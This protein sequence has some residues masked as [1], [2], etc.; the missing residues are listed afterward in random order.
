[1]PRG[2]I[3]KIFLNQARTC[4]LTID[5]VRIVSMRACVPAPEALNN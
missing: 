3:N 4:F 1:M 2:S 5:P